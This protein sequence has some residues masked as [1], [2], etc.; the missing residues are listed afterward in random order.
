MDFPVFAR[1]RSP[2]E[3]F[4]RYTPLNSQVPVRISGKLSQ[5]VMVNP[6]DFIFEEED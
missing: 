5:T 3:A 6:G 1:C 2:V 4:N